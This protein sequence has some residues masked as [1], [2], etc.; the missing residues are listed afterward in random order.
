MQDSNGAV[1]L[2]Y[3]LA[4]YLRQLLD[5][6][7]TGSILVERRMAMCAMVIACAAAEYLEWEGQSL[8]TAALAAVASSAAGAGSCAAQH[9]NS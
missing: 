4:D 6:A 3:E 5:A 8:D 2:A 7:P 9:V 1:G